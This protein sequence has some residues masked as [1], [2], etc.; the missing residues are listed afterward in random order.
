MD[1]FPTK[2]ADFLE[3]TATRVRSATVDRI[4]G[5]AKW[6]AIGIVLGVLGFVATIFLLV[7]TF[8]IL[9]HLFSGLLDSETWG[10]TLAY[11]VL[12]G[13]MLLLGTFLWSKRIPP[14][15]KEE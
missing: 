15:A 9:G 5:W 8:R 1:D 12:G 3:Q 13:L 14:A 11:A 6:G 7:A 10:F 4:A 2:I